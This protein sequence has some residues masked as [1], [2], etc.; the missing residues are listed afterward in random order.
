MS[1]ILLITFF[2]ESFLRELKVTM[3]GKPDRGRWRATDAA[4]SAAAAYRANREAIEPL[5]QFLAAALALAA[6]V[7]RRGRAPA[8]TR[9]KQG[10]PP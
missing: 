4:R 7:R 5:I 2:R 6:L 9:T 10:T 3:N 1:T 8:A